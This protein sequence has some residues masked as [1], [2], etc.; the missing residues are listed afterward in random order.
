MR[1][2]DFCARKAH[3]HW[4]PRILL[5]AFLVVTASC[6]PG[7]S[8]QPKYK[9]LASSPLFGDQTS[10]RPLP[11]GTVAQGHLDADKHFYLGKVNGADATTFPIL[12][13]SALMK[14][15]QQRFDI[16]CAVCHGRDGYGQGLVV[17][18]GFTAPPSYHDERLRAAPVGHLFDVITNGFGAMYSYG[19]RVAV[20]DRW[21]IIAYIRAL[22]LSQAASVQELSAQERARISTGGSTHD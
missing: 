21:A 7:M 12:V 9:P 22:Q 15:G 18:R 10:A 2:S 8:R 5:M 13:T 14:R 20:P 16:Y 17:T 11:A 1:V 3:G 19:A 4:G 6:Q